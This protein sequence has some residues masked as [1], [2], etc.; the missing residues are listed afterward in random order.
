M[1]KQSGVLKT[2]DCIVV[3]VG[4][5]VDQRYSKAEPA[6]VNEITLLPTWKL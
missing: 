1:L 6:W 3:F 5:G 2:P 4:P